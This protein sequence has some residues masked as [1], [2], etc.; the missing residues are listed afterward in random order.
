M[1]ERER[2]TMAHER[3][4]DARRKERPS[5]LG[6]VLGLAFLGDRKPKDRSDDRPRGRREGE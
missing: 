2:T 5:L 4:H 6:L 3:A 1:D